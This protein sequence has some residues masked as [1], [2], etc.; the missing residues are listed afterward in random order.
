MEHGL[1]VS[2]LRSLA[3]LTAS[4]SIRTGGSVGTGI[5]MMMQQQQGRGEW[6]AEARVIVA[7]AFCK[8]SCTYTPFSAVCAS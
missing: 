8:K 4:S 1:G 2:L 5:G 3:Q 7:A 6:S